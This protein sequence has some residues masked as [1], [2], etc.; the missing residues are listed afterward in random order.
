MIRIQTNAR[1]IMFK[2]LVKQ[3]CRITYYLPSNK[4][5]EV[6]KTAKNALGSLLFRLLMSGGVFVSPDFEMSQEAFNKQQRVDGK[7]AEPN[8]AEI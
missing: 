2:Y 3:H 6:S 5:D 1:K 7:N 4:I 8:A